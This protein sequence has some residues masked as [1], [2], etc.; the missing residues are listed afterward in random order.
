MHECGHPQTLV[1]WTSGVAALFC[2]D[3]VVL[4]VWVGRKWFGTGFVQLRSGFVA[5][6]NKVDRQAKGSGG[7]AGLRCAEGRFDKKA[8]VMNDR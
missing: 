1:Q 7:T 2:P 5:S 6:G 3:A 8:M 4:P